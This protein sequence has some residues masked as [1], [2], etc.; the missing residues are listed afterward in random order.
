MLKLDSDFLI[1]HPVHQPPVGGR[2]RTPFPPVFFFPSVGCVRGWWKEVGAIYS[3]PK[4]GQAWLPFHEHRCMEQGLHINHVLTPVPRCITGAGPV[5]TDV[6]PSVSSGCVI[7]R[8]LPVTSPLG[9]LGRL[10]SFNP[11]RSSRRGVC[12]HM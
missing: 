10:N 12:A 4:R 6:F 8:N 1:L 5:G 9:S 3:V 11:E 2:E 7:R